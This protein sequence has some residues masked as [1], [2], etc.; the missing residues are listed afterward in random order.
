MTYET[1]SETEWEQVGQVWDLLDQGELERARIE[2]NAL[3]RRRPGHPD[4]RI[5]DAAVALDEA[6]PAHALEALEGAETSAD[7]ALFFHL[8][9]VANYDLARFERAREDAERALAVRPD[10]ADTHDLLSRTCEYLGDHERAVRHAEEAGR[11]DPA[12]F[13]PALQVTDQE[14]DT[15]VEESLAELHPDIRRHLDE[16]PVLVDV[17]PRREILTAEEPP[18]SPDLLGLF[19]GRHLMERSVT[20]APGVPGAIYLFRRNLLRWC[21]DAEEL[22]R[23]I[24]IT[25]QHEIGHLLGLDEGDLE[26]RG[27]A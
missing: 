24:R 10:M 2:V 16:Y 26:D 19:L 6:E 21:R 9:A 25:V 14:F 12:A 11:L 27:L 20:D 22:R 17:L 1:L 18:L 13:P 7:P 3:L 15:V 8:R 5:V 4:L 23:E